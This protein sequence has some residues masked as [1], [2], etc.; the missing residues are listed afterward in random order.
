MVE[1]EKKLTSEALLQAKDRVLE[2]WGLLPPEHQATMLL[3]LLNNINH[4]DMSEWTRSAIAILYPDKEQ[5]SSMVSVSLVTRDKLAQLHIA[6]QELATLTDEDLREIA[7]RLE[8]AFTHEEFWDE[9]LL[10]ALEYHTE[11]VL[12]AK[13]S[14]PF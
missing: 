7:D 14:K 9:L 8:T 1:E 4:A 2:Q 10:Q 6:E 11:Q 13:R 3:V 5:P 12:L